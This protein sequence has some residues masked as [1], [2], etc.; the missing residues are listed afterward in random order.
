MELEKDLVEALANLPAY[1][2]SEDVTLEWIGADDSWYGHLSFANGKLSVAYRSSE[3]DYFEQ[4]SG[5][6][7]E[8]QS[9]SIKPLNSVSLDWIQ[10]LANDKIINSLLADL[11]KRLEE[12]NDSSLKSIHAIEKTLNS[13]ISTTSKDSEF[14]LSETSEEKL[15]KDWQS[16]REQIY[17]DPSESITRSSSYLESVCRKILND[18]NVPL[19]KKKDISSLVSACVNALGLSSDS[20]AENDLKQLI[21]GVK[22]IFQAI[23]S[24]RT[25][26]GT[27]HGSCDKDHKANETCA[28]LANTSAASVSIFLLQIHKEKLNNAFLRTADIRRKT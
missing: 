11:S 1:G 4:L 16:A 26:F 8:D 22:G 9:Y 17:I 12:L 19:P 6:P 15:L 13:Q 5:V 7:E 3:D 2:S 27:A 10:R 28:R 18:L 21:G 23:G 24:L 25:H 20:T 14:F